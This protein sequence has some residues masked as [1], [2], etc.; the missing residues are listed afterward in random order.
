M[1]SLIASIAVIAMASGLAQA[2]P[3]RDRHDPK[4]KAG[5][6][7]TDAS[8]SADRA[9][10]GDRA[11]QSAR[12]ARPTP[13]PQERKTAITLPPSAN[14]NG[15]GNGNGED[16]S[17]PRGPANGSPGAERADRPAP[18]TPPGK[19]REA[20]RKDR[21]TP[22]PVRTVAKARMAPKPS[23][24]EVQQFRT[25]SRQP[26][27]GCPHEL[28]RKF[29]GCADAARIYRQAKDYR[30]GYFAVRGLESAEY[31]YDEGYLLRFAGAD[32]LAGYVPLLGGGLSLGS[33][34][35]SSYAPVSVPDY[36]RNF[37]DLGPDAGYRYADDV[38]YRVDPT[39]Q[40]ITAVAAILTGDQIDVGDRLP[41]GYGIY[42]VPLG[43]RD[44]YRDGSNAIYRY[45][46]GYIYRADPKT[47]VVGAIIELL[48]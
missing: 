36:F 23:L 22:K 9:P 45:A 41:A 25:E 34:W 16:K 5:G 39:S 33:V 6:M 26:L 10:G 15:N 38:I 31:R 35:P 7:G 21:P 46:D 17:D 13:S 4:G 20:K 12:V 29:G 42:N 47:R 30:P 27:R 3:G 19:K 24:R 43:Y 28:D 18:A 37:Y 48:T 1:R 11:P 44:R 32:R 14:G 40:A 8:R 2:Q